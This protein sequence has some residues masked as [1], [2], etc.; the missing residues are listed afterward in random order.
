MTILLK[1]APRT[2]HSGAAVQMSRYS[3]LGGRG[4]SRDAARRAH[5]HASD[6]GDFLV[7]WSRLLI[8]SFP[9]CE[10]CAVHFGVTVQTAWNWREGI[11]CPLGH[12]VDHAQ[13]TLPRYTAVMR[14]Q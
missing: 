4:R 9:S 11:A 13:A 2:R 1:T 14:D 3:P 12:H 6:K 7:R 8:G 10:A 5:L